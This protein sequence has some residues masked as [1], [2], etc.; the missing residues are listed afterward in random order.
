[1]KG[2]LTHDSEWQA[3]RD[4]IGQDGTMNEKFLKY[5]KENDIFIIYMG[6]M[7]NVTEVDKREE[8]GRV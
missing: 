6:I 8:A 2:D 7:I 3:L 5:I 4:F 1:M